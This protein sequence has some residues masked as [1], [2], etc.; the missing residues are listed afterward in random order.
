MSRDKREIGGYQFPRGIEKV[1]PHP[2]LL[3]APHILEV[4]S[5]RPKLLSIASPHYG[6]RPGN[7]RRGVCVKG[8]PKNEKSEGVSDE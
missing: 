7:V 3:C 8:D 6:R 1:L 5:S 2:S 4:Q